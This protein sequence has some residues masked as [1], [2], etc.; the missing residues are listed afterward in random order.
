[1]VALINKSV[2]PLKFNVPFL[3]EVVF[4]S[5]G[6][7]FNI[8]FLLF[9][10]PWAPFENSWHLRDDYKRAHRRREVAHELS[11]HIRCIGL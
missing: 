11:R 5:Q 8:E 4:L 6:L 2:L 3:G 7:K 1:M 10:G 9:R